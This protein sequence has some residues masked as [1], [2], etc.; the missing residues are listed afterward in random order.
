[1]RDIAK[2]PRGL[3]GLLGL[4][5]QGR[6]IS[7]L[8]QTLAGTVEMTQPYTINDVER[9]NYTVAAPVLGSNQFVD[10]GTGA[11]I[12]VPAGEVWYIHGI[13]AVANVA[14]AGSIKYVIGVKPSGTVGQPILDQQPQSF[15]ASETAYINGGFA[16]RYLPSGWGITAQVAQI[17][18][19][20]ALNGA[21][22]FTRLKG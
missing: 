11:N 19:A 9:I 17:T 2:F 22:Y 20:F 3:I 14:V 1:M 10:T 13:M 5:D 21:V 12:I 16:G 15:L 7:D 6:S 8:A 18:G 4:S